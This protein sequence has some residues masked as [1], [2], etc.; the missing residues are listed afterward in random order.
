MKWER[1]SH[2][3]SEAK[4]QEDICFILMYWG[5]SEF[6]ASIEEGWLVAEK[7]D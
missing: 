2:L 5:E 3:R 1:E 6:E 4:L 7:D